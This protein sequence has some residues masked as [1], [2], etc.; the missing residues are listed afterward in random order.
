M[1]L[2]RLQSAGLTCVGI[3]QRFTDLTDPMNQVEILLKGKAPE[4]PEEA[5]LVQGRMTHEANPVASWCFGN[6]SIAKNGSGLIK[7]V[8]ETK[9]KSVIKTKRIDLTAAW[10]CA[11]ARARFYKGSIDL[12]A[13]ILDPDW[14]M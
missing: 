6:T 5:M 9:G 11:V 1:L 3:P 4:G 14:S 7:Y 10:I 2:Q 12:S 8:K 13:A